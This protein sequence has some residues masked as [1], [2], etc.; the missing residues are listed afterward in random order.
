MAEVQPIID[1][2]IYFVKYNITY[3]L[4]RGGVRL[5]AGSDNNRNRF[6]I[7]IVV[8]IKMTHMQM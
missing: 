1:L 5:E 2:V 6:I 7:I 3:L 4:A 8:I